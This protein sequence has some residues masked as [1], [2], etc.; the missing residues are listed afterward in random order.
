MSEEKKPNTTNNQ[1]I[2]PQNENNTNSQNAPIQQ[3]VKK[4]NIYND[5]IRETIT[6]S[7]DEIKNK[8]K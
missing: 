2:N 8:N 3:Q 5:R 6:K 4:P 7:F 1:N